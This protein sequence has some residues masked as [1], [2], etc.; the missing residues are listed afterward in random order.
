MSK[1]LICEEEPD[2]RSRGSLCKMCG[3]T[4][5]FPI[6]REGFVFCCS[7]CADH[8]MRIIKHSNPEERKRILEKDVVI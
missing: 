2:M 4:S 8:F 6:R 1:C 7:S 3:M 5:E